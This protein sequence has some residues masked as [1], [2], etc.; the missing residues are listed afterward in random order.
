VAGDVE[1]RRTPPRAVGPQGYRLAV[2]STIQIAAQS[3]R[4]VFYGGRTLIQLLMQ[5]RSI[6]HGVARDRPGYRQRGLMVDCSRTVY[7][8]GWI[9]R[10]IRA[11]ALV[12]QNL[13]HLHLTD[14]Q[15]WGVASKAFPKVVSPGAFSYADIRRIL[16]VAKRYHVEV[17][18]EVDMPG[19]MAAFL[20]RHPHLML[21][22][23]VAGGSLPPQQ[24]LTDKL[25]ITNPIVRRDVRKMVLE[26]MK[27][28][29]GRYFDMGTDETLVPPEVAVF[30]QLE[31]YAVQK[32][33]PGAT[34][35]DALHGFIN[36]VDRVV[37][38]HGKVLRIWNDQMGGTGVVPVNRDI[39]VDWWTG[40]SP[41]SDP[42]TVA[43]RTLLD[44]GFKIVNAGWYPNYYAS[45][46]GPASGKSPMAKVY[47]EWHVYEFDSV[48]DKNGNQLTIQH[49]PA[50]HP[51]VLGDAMSIWG[52]LPES[53]KQTAKGIAPSL[54]VIAQKTWRT[55]PLFA[56]YSRFA[57]LMK[58]LGI[59]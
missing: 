44:K 1:L 51:H 39:V 48:A 4:G 33:G 29:P 21:K 27:L 30:P 40:V 15:R 28:F 26:Y 31:T 9:L 52:P 6:H 59:T 16:R 46:I 7:T 35:S 34:A 5:H 37:R 25:D 17:F 22:P 42:V 3:R 54:A 43:P 2:G 23:L 57:R 11:M 55:P 56:S 8:V 13:L 14:D 18:P 19:H 49:V 24:Y 36:W 41:L 32:Y 20:A 58:R 50:H 47:R 38:K 12:K 53:T 45:D 10:E